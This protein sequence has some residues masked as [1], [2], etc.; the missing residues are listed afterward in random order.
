M[1]EVW[2][3]K[4]IE[5]RGINF[6]RLGKRAVRI[7]ESELEKFIRDHIVPAR[8]GDRKESKRQ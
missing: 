2:A 8:A 3:R 4:L 5:R 6:I 1:S 7:P